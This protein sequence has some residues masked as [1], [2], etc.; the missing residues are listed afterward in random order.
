MP[1]PMPQDCNTEHFAAALREETVSGLEEFIQQHGLQLTDD[2]FEELLLVE[3]NH[4]L[5]TGKFVHESR[6][7][8][9]F[10]EFKLAVRSAFSNALA[11]HP[12]HFG[13][14]IPDPGKTDSGRLEVFFKSTNV[15]TPAQFLD[16]DE[17]D[18][19]DEPVIPEVQMRVVKGPQAGRD[20]VFIRPTSILVGRSADAH[21]HL[22]DDEKCSRLHCRFEVNPPQCTVVD[23]KSTNGTL[24]NGDAVGRFDL[25]DGDTVQI[26]RTKI[27]IHIHESRS[28]SADSQVPGSLDTFDPVVHA[29]QI[30]GYRVEAQV[31]RGQ[32]GVVYRGVQISSGRDVAIKVSSRSAT[33]SSEEMQRF[34][35]EASISVRLKHPHIVETL[36]FGVHDDAPH[37]VLEYIHVV[38][39]GHLISQ[40]SPDERHHHSVRLMI[41]VLDGLS[42]AH[43]LG[44]VHRD[45][46]LANMLAFNSADGLQAK[47]ADFGLAHQSTE[48]TEAE[49]GVRGTAAYMAPEIILDPSRAGAASDIYAAGVCLYQL[50]CGRRPHEAKRISKL[51]FMILNEPATS[52]TQYDPAIPTRLV[53]I[54]D[55][56]ISKRVEDRY[57][58]AADFRDDLQAVLT[59]D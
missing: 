47:I 37:L 50:L 33:P 3:I 46:K 56:A 4:L 35:R 13:R 38:D 58:T 45:V 39:V 1:S 29:P 55:R 54:I 30:P 17:D 9:R 2:R 10:G 14:L 8:R 32:F 27:R 16:Q 34:I 49:Q 24:V 59:A 42:Y 5:Q 19:A 51:V 52:I 57:Q 22:E 20:M 23:L 25:R 26:G 41:G 43:S 7:A 53:K 31:G 44:I 48:T 12:E 21:L 15:L 36:D 6:L 18:E 28:L 40:L 11:T